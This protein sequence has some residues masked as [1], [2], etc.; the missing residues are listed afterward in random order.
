[1]PKDL[2]EVPKQ[3]RRG[4]NFVFAET[5]DDVLKVALKR[6]GAGQEIKRVWTQRVRRRRP[7]VSVATAARQKHEG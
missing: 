3:V 7:L 2:D 5:M 4:M 1:V 6:R